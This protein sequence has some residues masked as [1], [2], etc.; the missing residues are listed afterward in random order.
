MLGEDRCL[1]VR[2]PGRPQLTTL[3]VDIADTEQRLCSQ[4]QAHAVP[5]LVIP[6]ERTGEL[7]C[8][9]VE[10]T[11]CQ[12]RGGPAAPPRQHHRDREGCVP[13]SRT[14]CAVQFG[15]HLSGLSPLDP[16]LRRAH[17]R[18]QPQQGI[19]HRTGGV[20]RALPVVLGG[21]TTAIRGRHGRGR[22][23]G[24]HAGVRIVAAVQ[25][26]HG[27]PG[28]GPGLPQRPP[29]AVGGCGP[30]RRRD[31][32]GRVQ[33]A[34]GQV[35]V[36]GDCPFRFAQQLVDRDQPAV[37]AGPVAQQVCDRRTSCFLAIG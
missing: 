33:L 37:R 18:Q 26:G 32:R 6:R 4:R 5:Q 27:A 25:R 36:G 34:G 21:R 30:G 31:L 3:P 14:Q 9:P 10:F 23:A 20:L 15:K 35:P 13:A 28:E 2:R 19:A 12:Q 7:G 22:G 1:L 17:H 24:H 8:G 29:G 11:E 16:L